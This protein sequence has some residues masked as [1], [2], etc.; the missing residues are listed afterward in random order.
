MHLVNLGDSCFETANSISIS[1]LLI[2]ELSNEGLPLLNYLVFGKNS[3][4]QV[5]TA[6]QGGL[7]GAGGADD[8]DHIAL[9]YGKI[10]VL[11]NFMVT[12]GLGKVFDI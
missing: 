2:N 11:Q 6:K 4:Q 12:K 8:G 1:S 3:F 7:A 9:V 10:N 5:D